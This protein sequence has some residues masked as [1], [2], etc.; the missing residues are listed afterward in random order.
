[1]IFANLKFGSHV[2]K[3]EVQMSKRSKAT[4]AANAVFKLS[5]VKILH[6]SKIK[7][8]VRA[9]RPRP[10]PRSWIRAVLVSPTIAVST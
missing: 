3:F 2:V 9:W 6:L 5:V 8:R 10:G 4:F 1:M 7:K